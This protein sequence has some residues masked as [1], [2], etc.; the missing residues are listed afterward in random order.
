MKDKRQRL[1]LA[2]PYWDPTIAALMH[3]P[4]V[5]QITGP[6]APFL[7]SPGSYLGF[8]PSVLSP[9]PSIDASSPFSRPGSSLLFHPSLPFGT[10]QIPTP[11]TKLPKA[12]HTCSTTNYLLPP[13]LQA[14]TSST[15]SCLGCLQQHHQ[16]ASP[17]P[18]NGEEIQS[19][20]TYI[21]LCEQNSKDHL[22]E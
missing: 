22:L 18:P 5:P 1:A 10:A 9:S 2:W 14:F 11:V 13:P 15:A 20:C 17:V 8:T 19:L 4:F 16:H 21:T 3:R 7:P 6:G 12:P